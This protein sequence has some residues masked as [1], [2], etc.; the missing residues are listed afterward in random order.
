MKVAFE[1]GQSR[2]GWIITNRWS[3]RLRGRLEL[4]VQSRK[5]PRFLCVVGGAAQ[6]YVMREVAE[7]PERLQG[8]L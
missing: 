5:E 8:R 6:L 3:S 2:I 7:V 1:I 4:R